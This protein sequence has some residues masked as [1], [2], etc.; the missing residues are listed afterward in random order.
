[1]ST[2]RIILLTILGIVLAFGGYIAYT[3]AT[4]RNHS[5]K[6]TAEFSKDGLDMS[7][8]YCRPY[9]KGRLIFGSSADGALQPYG[10]YWRMGANEATQIKINQTV[11]FGGQELAAGEYVVY[12][13]PGE[14][15]WT[16]GL[17]SE[18]GRWG[19]FEVDHEL[20]IMQVEVS[21]G[22]AASEF[23]QF[24]IEFEEVDS[25]TVHMNLMW[26]KTKVPVPIVR[27]S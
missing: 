14:S 9:K 11:N 2:R 24:T 27:N 8:V 7:V 16:I 23:E 18:L 4:T 12:A 25:A 15:N 5:P 13:V 3:L 21:P 22:T 1:M 6:S 20:D 10:E 19:A 26:D 17:N